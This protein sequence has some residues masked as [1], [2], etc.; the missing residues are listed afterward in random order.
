[1]Y[2]NYKYEI[3]LDLHK[4]FSMMAVIKDSGE[5]LGYDKVPNTIEHFDIFVKKYP[6]AKRI[7]FESTRNFYWLV[8]YLK[9][10]KIDYIMS[11]P[12]L[13]RAIAHVHAKNDKYDSKILA[14]LTRCNLI[15][16]CYLPDKQI[17]DL[18]ELLSQRSKFVKTSTQLKNKIHLLLIK[19]NYRSE[20]KYIFG[21]NGVKWIESCNL[22]E[23]YKEMLWDNYEMLQVCKI[24]IDEYHIKIKNR[25]YKHPYYKLISSIPGFAI[26]H[27]ATIISRIDDINRFKNVSAFIRYSGLSVNTRESAD[28]I[29]YGHLNRQS[30]KYLRTSF[31]EGALL[32]IKK[33][34][35]L[36]AFYDHLRGQKGHGCAIVAVARKIARSAYFMLK[37]NSTYKHRKIQPKWMEKNSS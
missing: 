33:D 12:F 26:I 4:D 17:R 2:S 8:D 16:K 1:M 5:F 29:K 22:P 25:I 32:T 13:N 23:V 21:P 34:P 37:N 6:G 11:N 18:R 36:T 30:D 10:K 7:T 15:A 35:G 19:F 31:V 3:G 28:K 14:D 27:S 24:K 20:Y 9:S